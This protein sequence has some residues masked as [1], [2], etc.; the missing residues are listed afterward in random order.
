MLTI[1]TKE[2]LDCI[3]DA[4]IR[5]FV[6]LS[7]LLSQFIVDIKRSDDLGKNLIQ[8]KYSVRTD[9]KFPKIKINHP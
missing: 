3:V 4:K 2:K 7:E 9:E 6:N 1:E 5:E 8:Q